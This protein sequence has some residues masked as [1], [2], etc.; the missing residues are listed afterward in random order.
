MSFPESEKYSHSKRPKYFTMSPTTEESLYPDSNVA[1]EQHNQAEAEMKANDTAFHQVEGQKGVLP[2]TMKHQPDSLYLDSNVAL[3][4][5]RQSQAEV[6][7][8][9][10]AFD[11]AEGQDTEGQEGVIAGIKHQFD[12]MPSSSSISEF[13]ASVGSAA[14]EKIVAVKDTLME[15]ALPAAQGALRTVQSHIRSISGGSNE[16]EETVS[17]GLSREEHECIDKMSNEQI[18]DFLRHKQMSNKHSRPTK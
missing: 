18:C 10:A 2:G 14:Q 13:G 6:D 9:N 16:V 3:E 1:L 11:Q 5:R 8:N 4:Q 7:V 17:E 12:S 15:G